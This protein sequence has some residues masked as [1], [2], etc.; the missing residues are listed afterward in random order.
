MH[1][2]SRTQNLLDLALIKSNLKRIKR[3]TLMIGPFSDEREDT[4]RFYWRD[5]A[6]GSPGEGAEL[7]FTHAPIEMRCFD[8]SG[9]FYDEERFLL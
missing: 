4:I 5:L 3:V 8:C 7:Q 2:F 1:E 6:K 9:T